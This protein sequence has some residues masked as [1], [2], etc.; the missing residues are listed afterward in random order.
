[1]KFNKIIKTAL[2]GMAFMALAGCEDAGYQAI[3]NSLYIS[4]AAPS[5]RF[6]QQVENL[7]VRG[8]TQTT[9][10]VRLAQPLTQDV[11]VLLDFAPEFVEEYNAA[12]GTSYVALP[13]EYMDFNR[14][15]TIPAGSLS[16][17]A[18]N[19]SIDEFD[20]S[21]G[22]AYCVPVKIAS[23]DA[24]VPVTQKSSRI[25]YLLQLPLIQVVPQM[26]YQP[27]PTS[28]DGW[29]VSTPAWTLEGWV[30]M[31]SYSINNQAIFN[32]E[33]SAGTE[34]YIRFGDAAI[35]YNQLQVKTGGSQVETNTLFQTSQWY[36]L[37]FTFADNKLSVYVN[38]QLDCEKD[39][40][41]PNYVI[42]KL[43][44]CS[45]GSTYFRANA[46]MAQIRFWSKALSASTI[47]DAMGRA[48]PANSEGLF[49][50]WKLDEGQGMV[51]NDATMNG[52]N[53][54]CSSA[55]TWQAPVDFSNPNN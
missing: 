27:S 41:V 16:S 10:H 11:H 6:T 31:S 52:R 30:W 43:S 4:E 21:E 47:Q 32:A 38:G 17:D 40:T 33:V 29:N 19:I 48:V 5:G 22:L 9:L 20:N 23:T 28:N 45:S 53:L 34:I 24:S 8:A 55:P 36:H 12:N 1:M 49:G 26:N 7:V 37:A 50:Y 51:F 46:R 54:N 25:M 44:I 39:I 3:T 2:F 15:V 42:N 18:V 35:P 13:E 14:E